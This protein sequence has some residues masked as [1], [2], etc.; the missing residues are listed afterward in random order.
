MEDGLLHRELSSEI[1]G[2][3]Y[4][5]YNGLGY[6]FLESIYAKAMETQLRKRGLQVQREF[7]IRVEFEG[8]LLGIH[9][10]DMIVNQTIIIENKA[11]EQLSDAPRKQL[12][13]YLAAMKLDLGM[14]LHF[15]PRANYYRILGPKRSD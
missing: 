11:T 15:G 12:K 4:H 3:F 1:I 7:P 6:G 9:R 2:A 5:V 10:G 14:L 13:N 8:E